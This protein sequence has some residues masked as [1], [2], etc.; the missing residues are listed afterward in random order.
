RLWDAAT[1]QHRAVIR[2]SR[3]EH[4]EAFSPDGRLLAMADFRQVRLWDLASGQELPPIPTG[5]EQKFL[6]F[7][8]DGKILA[9]RRFGKVVRLWDVVRS[10]E[11]AVLKGEAPVFSPDGK[12]LATIVVDQDPRFE[13]NQPRFVL[14]WDVATGQLKATLPSGRR[15]V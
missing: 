11:R 6:V 10:P 9:S 5:E 7:S 13:L 4:A 2:H 8:P 15:S 12:T 3:D 14:L 1:G